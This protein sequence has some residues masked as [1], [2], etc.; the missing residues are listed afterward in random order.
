MEFAAL[1][2]DEGRKALTGGYVPRH[3]VSVLLR[4]TPKASSIPSHEL[5]GQGSLLLPPPLTIGNVTTPPVSG[6]G[7]IRVAVQTKPAEICTHYT[8]QLR[9]LTLV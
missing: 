8:G 5:G 9:P 6:R 4:A 1:G 7:V 3:G 2:A